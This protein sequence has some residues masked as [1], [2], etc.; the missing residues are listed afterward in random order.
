MHGEAPQDRFIVA[1][2]LGSIDHVVA[3]LDPVTDELLDEVRRMLAVA[4]HEQHGATPGVVEPRHQRGLLAEIARQRH[5]LNVERL[6]GKFACD[7]ER[8]VGAAVI[9]I[10][11]LAGEA[12]AVLQRFCQ[13]AEPGVQRGESGGLIIQRHDDR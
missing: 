12:V 3:V 8:G 7:A 9:D 4:I 5:H 1:I 10:D 6:G 11:H 2:G 13:F